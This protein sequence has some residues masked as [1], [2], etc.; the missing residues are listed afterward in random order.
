MAWRFGRDNLLFGSFV[1]W[2]VDGYGVLLL[3]LESRAQA[4][5]KTIK[6][7]SLGRANYNNWGQ[8][9]HAA[10]IMS[11]AFRALFAWVLTGWNSL[12][13]LISSYTYRGS[14]TSTNRKKY[15]FLKYNYQ[16]PGTRLPEFLLE[17]LD[18]KHT[19][20]DHY[21]L[22]S[23][24]NLNSPIFGKFVDGIKEV[25]SIKGLG[26]VQRVG[27]KN[28]LQR[29]QWSSLMETES[30]TGLNRQI[31]MQ[32]LT[33]PS[34]AIDHAKPN[35]FQIMGMRPHWSQK[36]YVLIQKNDDK[37]KTLIYTKQYFLLVDCFPHPSL[38]FVAWDI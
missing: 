32:G 6:N 36:R 28:K 3:C 22:I 16:R 1:R 4:S 9:L 34:E 30:W 23:S 33:P 29:S 18:L 10:V 12:V 19:N 11:T 38:E 35:C 2:G 21:I 24:R 13:S 37:F 27:V 31:F 8:D 25:A 20:A 17:N 7:S 5:R 14:E 26:S 15:V